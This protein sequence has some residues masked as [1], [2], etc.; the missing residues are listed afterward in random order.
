V[1]SKN[2]PYNEETTLTF[3]VQEMKGNA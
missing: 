3:P 2:T 1:K